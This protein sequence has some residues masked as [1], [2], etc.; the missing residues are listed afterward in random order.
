MT[1]SP[2]M[3]ITESDQ[4]N[5][6]IGISFSANYVGGSI[7][8]VG[9][10][11]STPS[12]AVR[13]ISISNETDIQIIIPI[14]SF[15][16]SFS[17]RHFH[18]SVYQEAVNSYSGS[19]YPEASRNVSST[20]W[21]TP[22]IPAR[23][24][25]GMD[26]LIT[27]YHNNS[28]FE[29]TSDNCILPAYDA[30]SVSGLGLSGNISPKYI[31]LTNIMPPGRTLSYYYDGDE[32]KWEKKELMYYFNNWN[33]E[34]LGSWQG[35]P[36]AFVK[37]PVYFYFDGEFSSYL[38]IISSN[39]IHEG[40]GVDPIGNYK[41]PETIDN[42]IT[43]YGKDQ[44]KTY[45]S[46]SKRKYSGK[47]VE[48]ITNQD[49]ADGTNLESRGFIETPS[50]KDLKLDA[51][52]GKYIRNTLILP[53]NGIGA[54]VVTAPDGKR[55]NYALPVYQFEKL[56]KTRNAELSVNGKIV[57]TTRVDMN[58]YAYTWLLTSITGP[59]YIDLN[60]SGQA[61]VGDAGYWVRFDYGK[62]TDSYVW[63]FP[64]ESNTWEEIYNGDTLLRNI[65]Y[66]R[67]QVFYLDRIQTAS[68]TAYFIKGL[69]NDG[70][71]FHEAGFNDDWRQIGSK[72][73]TYV[74]VS[75]YFISNGGEWYPPISGINSSS[76]FYVTESFK[77]ISHSSPPTDYYSSTL[78]LK[79][80][81]L[82]PNS[83]L[84]LNN[85]STQPIA[86]TY[87]ISNVHEE[88]KLKIY[89]FGGLQSIETYFDDITPSSNAYLCNNVYD[90]ND[91]ADSPE[92]LKSA[93]K[94]V[95]FDY[96]YSLCPNTPNTT[97]DNTTK[98]KLTLKSVSFD[99]FDKESQTIKHSIPPYLFS[100]DG[101]NTSYNKGLQD[102][103][104]FSKSQDIAYDLSSI[105]Y[106][107][108]SEL[109]IQS[110]KDNYSNELY[111][112]SF[113]SLANSLLTSTPYGNFANGHYFNPNFNYKDYIS[114]GDIIEINSWVRIYEVQGSNSHVQEVTSTHTVTNITENSIQFD[115]PNQEDWI[116]YNPNSEDYET[117]SGTMS[118]INVAKTIFGGGGNRVKSLSMKNTSAGIVEKTIKFCYSE[119]STDV[120]SGVTVSVPVPNVSLRRPYQELLPGPGVFYRYFTTEEYNK[121]DEL[122]SRTVTQFDLPETVTDPGEEL[123]IPGFFRVE[124]LQ[125]ET[126]YSDWSSGSDD[127]GIS[128]YAKRYLIHDNLS[129]M[130][131]VLNTRTY[132][133][134]NNLISETVFSY[135]TP[136]NKDQGV[137]RESYM[138]RKVNR[139]W[140]EDH[141]SFG[142]H[143]FLNAT[144]IIHYPSIVESTTTRVLNSTTTT[145][146]KEYDFLTGQPTVVWTA[147][148]NASY[149][150]EVTLPAYYVY[151]G[152]GSKID[153]PS[154]PNMLTQVAGN[155][156]FASDANAGTQGLLGA[157]AQTWS[158]STKTRQYIEDA[159][160][161]CYSYV[162]PMIQPC[163]RKNKSFIFT[164]PNLNNDG[165][166]DYNYGTWI[167]D[168]PSEF[169]NWQ[170]IFGSGSNGPWV[171]S[172]EIT[173]Y[174]KY[175]QPIESY[176]INNNP[177]ASKMGYS[178]TKVIGTASFANQASFACS[179]FEERNPIDLFPSSRDWGGEVV[180]S[181]NSSLLW[182]YSRFSSNPD[183]RFNVEPHTGNSYCC[184]PA[185]SF[186][187]GFRTRKLLYGNSRD[188]ML[189]GVTYRASVW[190]HASSPDQVHLVAHL[191]GNNC[192]ASSYK[193]VAKNA[194][195]NLRIGDWIRL[196]V[197][198]EV[199]AAY[200]SNSTFGTDLRVYV[201][202][203]SG[204]GEAYIDD[205][206]VQPLHSAVNTYVFNAL[207]DQLMAVLDN[208][209]MATVYEYA[210]DGSLARTYRETARDG[211]KR[212]KATEYQHH[213][214]RDQ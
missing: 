105:L 74:E 98:G 48:W 4:Q 14:K 113:R 71:G 58:K 140:K 87:S 19:L 26:A 55:Y 131:R 42:Q 8:R 3:S 132:N 196:V 24:K 194:A 73:R 166:F 78:F 187:P 152:M 195:Q 191:T 31:S 208:E 100:Y 213:F 104:G 16:L 63:K 93:I 155:Y 27:S 205:F 207:N 52:S 116:Q 126:L 123:N 108:G 38:E 181:D 20:N 106:P 142:A 138:S 54:F 209:N 117:L 65:T 11:L 94:V 167:V 115:P 18:W 129:A 80:I 150:K 40:S 29:L 137:L 60:N 43:L 183:I 102:N 202:N 109:S 41:T 34:R 17:Y 169:A 67:K 50:M 133:P 151:P 139:F 25:R 122:I 134:K 172:N 39:F 95:T 10:G 86:S 159:Q 21:G 141:T 33:G 121:E 182:S 170:T 144:S 175:S 124:V 35:S 204:N 36:V 9:I 37:D 149:E 51:V 193:T 206:R 135:K 85:S 130:G 77:K 45:H 112:N 120:S 178:N 164:T 153:D 56:S 75:P 89:N 32:I 160:N 190:V 61:D 136:T 13:D 76:G 68:H 165:T 59:D 156:R 162:T 201:W 81:V 180:S 119:P 189:T 91:L 70:C 88:R 12:S 173:C 22:D 64:V 161:Q 114:V 185:S 30:Y 127:N 97:P 198:I 197:D 28:T 66:G 47:V 174:N 192:P 84:E 158:N 143:W 177:G 101:V 147:K 157:S 62:W 2:S 44:T 163:Y 203:N 211:G 90:I 184:V 96:D 23:G 83:V 128:I 69:R 53:K 92:T 148:D 200:S 79:E 5:Y 1:F 6:S 57:E 46:S 103:W 15:W 188:A 168:Q 145:R 186:G 212:Y 146:V 7:N 154:L 176:D 110:E 210:P 125:N 214:K 171:L 118:F 82:V 72:G 99:Y 49:I 111:H 179:G 199:P 107:T